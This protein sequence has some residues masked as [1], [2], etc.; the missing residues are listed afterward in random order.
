MSSVSP[1]PSPLIEQFAWN[2][3][4]A[5][6]ADDK[7]RQGMGSVFMTMLQNT[8]PL[9]KSDPAEIARITQGLMDCYKSREEAGTLKNI[10]NILR[11]QHFLQA[12]SFV[13]KKGQFVSDQFR[14]GDGSTDAVFYDI[15]SGVQKVTIELYK[16]GVRVHSVQGT[17][18]EGRH[19]LEEVLKSLEAGTYRI[20]AWGTDQQGGEVKLTSLIAGH[21]HSIHR[22]HQGLIQASLGHSR[23]PIRQL[24]GIGE[25]TSLLSQS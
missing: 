14:W 1:S 3:D 7:K 19:S 23:L 6:V 11:E 9:E 24:Q 20:H 2:P 8:N 21:I 4:P 16:D 18:K 10:E 13:D 22:D 15:P 25:T 17:A 5:K 12:A